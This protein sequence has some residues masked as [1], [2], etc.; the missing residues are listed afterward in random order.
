MEDVI[1]RV[2]VHFMTGSEVLPTCR[3]TEACMFSF[4]AVSTMVQS[5]TERHGQ[6]ARERVEAAF[7]HHVLVLQHLPSL[8]QPLLLLL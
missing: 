4:A 3:I 1:L 8:L 5:P 7:L 6:D 2:T